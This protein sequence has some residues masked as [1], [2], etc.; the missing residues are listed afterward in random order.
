MPTYAALVRQ[1]FENLH[2][3]QVPY[4]PDWYVCNPPLCSQD[5]VESGLPEVG[6]TVNEICHS[7]A[8]HHPPRFVGCQSGLRKLTRP[9]C[10]A[11]GL[12]T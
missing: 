9:F 12:A 11:K 3:F 10:Y 1:S 2:S 4:Q 5:G 8:N 7:T 6:A